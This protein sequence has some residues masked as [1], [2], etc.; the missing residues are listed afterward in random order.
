[1]T[2]W[3]QSC[4]GIDV[5]LGRAGSVWLCA[6]L[7]TLLHDAT[8]LIGCKQAP[9]LTKG[10]GGVH[11]PPFQPESY[12]KKNKL[13][14]RVIIIHEHPCLPVYIIQYLFHLCEQG[15][16]LQNKLT[17]RNSR[18]LSL[19]HILSFQPGLPSPY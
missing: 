8:C 16:L 6:C 1:M 15:S 14:D 18:P 11:S 5:G 7:C 2:E 10:G 9:V 17:D 3:L 12:L 4:L 13:V 19:F